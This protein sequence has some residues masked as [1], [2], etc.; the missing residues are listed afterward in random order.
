MEKKTV[1]RQI[2]DYAVITVSCLIY[3]IGISLFLDPNSLAP[4]GVTGVSIILNR[5][6]EVETGTL[7]LLINIPILI[8]GIWKF[9]MK[10]ILSTLYATTL[11]STFTNLL[12]PIGALTE[13]PF[14]AALAGSSLMAL[15]IGWI[16]KCG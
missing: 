12:M 9:G 8:L 15:A 7:I 11:T 2:R 16:F 1:T 10:F 3:A 4:G 6:I 5:L 13:E 14:V